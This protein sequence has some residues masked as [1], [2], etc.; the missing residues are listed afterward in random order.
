VRK[1]KEAL[2]VANKKIGL[3]VN[4]EE[5]KYIVLYR[6]QHAGQNHYIC[7]N[8]KSFERMEQFKY[9]GAN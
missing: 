4:A 3:D 9:V 7:I 6:D 5:T 1:S 2:N 8:N